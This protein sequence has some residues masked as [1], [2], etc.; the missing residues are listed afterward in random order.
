M[1]RSFLYLLL[2]TSTLTAGFLACQTNEPQAAEPGDFS[3]YFFSVAGGQ[4]VKLG[5]TYQNASGEFFT[6]TT[7]N[8]FVSNVHLTR[9]N[10]TGGLRSAAG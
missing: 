2:L 9:T 6:P 1:R 7:F 3:L 10:G 8:Y 5:K 4:P